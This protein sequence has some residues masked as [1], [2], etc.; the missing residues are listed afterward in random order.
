MANEVTG[1]S[2]SREAVT[3]VEAADGTTGASGG[4]GTTGEAVDDEA[5]V[6]SAPGAA[7]R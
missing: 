5:G 6:T 1:V 2:G 4:D 3:A 7:D